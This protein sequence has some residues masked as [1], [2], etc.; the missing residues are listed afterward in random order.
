MVGW[1]TLTS[2]NGSRVHLPLSNFYF[3]SQLFTSS[4]LTSTIGNQP[5]LKKAIWGFYS[6]FE[7]SGGKRCKTVNL[8]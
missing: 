7:K 1:A 5:R 3:Q 6:G 8:K 4:K 2:V